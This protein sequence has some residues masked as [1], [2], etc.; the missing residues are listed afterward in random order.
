L[1][2]TNLHIYRYRLLWYDDVKGEMKTLIY[3]NCQQICKIKILRAVCFFSA[4][5]AILLGIV[6]IYVISFHRITTLEDSRAA[7][8]VSQLPV[9]NCSSCYDR[10]RIHMNQ[11]V[12]C[13]PNTIFIG[14]RW[15]FIRFFRSNIEILQ[16]NITFVT[17]ASKSGTT[18]MVHILSQLKYIYFI[19]RRIHRKGKITF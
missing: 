14:V 7:I 17:K 13:L 12:S 3:A 15:H 18:S 1:N 5:A 8:Y 2:S 6:C 19:N 10:C 4:I 16:R 9:V 11:M